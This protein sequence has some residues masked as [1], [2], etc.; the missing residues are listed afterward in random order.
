MRVHDQGRLVAAGSQNGL[1]TLLSLSSDL[2]TMEKN[3][4]NVLAAVSL[5]SPYHSKLFINLI[6]C[7]PTS[8][9]QHRRI[10]ALRL[11]GKFRIAGDLFLVFHQLFI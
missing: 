10:H 7:D 9:S 4:K 3:E 8:M 2:C 6:L 11:F 1:T 5:I